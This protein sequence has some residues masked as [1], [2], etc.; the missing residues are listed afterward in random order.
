MQCR[1]LFR[2]AFVTGCFL[3]TFITKAAATDCRQVNISV[4]LN[5]DSV[6]KPSSRQ[7]L[8]NL[9]RLTPLKLIDGVTPGMELSYERIT[10]NTFST[11]VM[12]SWLLPKR[13]WDSKDG[14][15]P[16]IRG[17]RAAIEEKYYLGHE[18]PEGY[19]VAFE[20]DYLKKRY[21]TQ[22]ICDKPNDTADNYPDYSDTFR[23]SRQTI[24]GNFKIGYQVELGSF[25]LDFYIG[26][27][28]RYRNVVQHDRL[29]PADELVRPRHPNV[30]WFQHH[31]G[32]FWTVSIPCNWRIGFRF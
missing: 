28:L 10:G 31:A 25:Y 15:D 7:P 2:A 30:H 22:W 4:V 13:I 18:A 1:L 21:V 3:L 8:P 14:I 27:G 29:N 26:L 16:A 17:F 11:Q 5:N 12:V 20:L 24:S 32:S 19:Y 23:I 9:I 6:P